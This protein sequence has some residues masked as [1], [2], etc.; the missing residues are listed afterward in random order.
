M[1]ANNADIA[2]ADDVNDDDDNYYGGDDDDDDDDGGDDDDDGDRDDDVMMMRMRRVMM[3]MMLLL[4]LMMMI[5]SR[6]GRVCR[7]RYLFEVVAPP[8]LSLHHVAT[9]EDIY[10][11]MVTDMLQK[12]I[13]RDKCSGSPNT[14]TRT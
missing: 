6:W 1:N 11:V 12:V 2:A 3:L 7:D 14:G 4:L 10:A 5:R 9:L 13:Y 8:Y